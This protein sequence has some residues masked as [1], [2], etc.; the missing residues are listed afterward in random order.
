MV[1]AHFPGAGKGQGAHPPGAGMAC[2]LPAPELPLLAIPYII[3]IIIAIHFSS[4]II[5]IFL[6]NVIVIK[7]SIQ[8]VKIE[9]IRL[10]IVIVILI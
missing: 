5:I 6:R 3:T 8:L 2:A 1:S 7:K 9:I 4:T 10:V